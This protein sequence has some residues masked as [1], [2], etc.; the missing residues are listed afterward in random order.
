VR[1]PGRL[2]R[3]VEALAADRRV[4]YL[5]TGGTAAVVFWVI[6][7]AGWL[8]VHSWLSYTPW[9]VITSLI[10][11]LVM[12]P[13]YRNRVFRSDVGW[14]VGF[15]K[16]YAISLWGLLFSLVIMPL[17]IEL[18]DVPVVVATAIALL[19]Q[20]LVNYQMLKFWAFRSRRRSDGVDGTDLVDGAER[21]TGLDDESAG[22][23]G[24]GRVVGHDEV[25]EFQ[26]RQ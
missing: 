5:V 9:T 21:L 15:L 24:G 14:F 19:L 13:V 6:F 4:R 3:L 2:G 12:Y 20:P 17:L 26:R 16:F 23:D 18:A 8:V 11:A 1:I 10:T 22:D 25:E 7:T